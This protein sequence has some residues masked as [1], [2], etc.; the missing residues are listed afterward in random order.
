MIHSILSNDLVHALSWTLIHSLWQIIAIAFV[1]KVILKNIARSRANLRYYICFAALSV[2]SLTSL[3][4]FTSYYA[5]YQANKAERIYETVIT[6]N[7]VSVPASRPGSETFFS[8][9]ENYFPMLLQLWILGTLIFLIKI[10]LAYAYTKQLAANAQ[11]ES[12]FLTKT[13]KKLNKKFRIYRIINIKESSK[14]QTPMVLG[15]VKPLILFPVGLIN[16]LSTAEAEAIIAHE[17]AHIKRHDFIFN[18]LQMFVEAIFYFHPAIWHISAQINQERENCCDDM[19]IEYTGNKVSY[20]KTLIKLQ[21]LKSSNNLLAPALAM[22]GNKSSFSKRI[23]RLL[24]EKTPS[25]NHRDKIIVLLLVFISMFLGAKNMITDEKT[26][27]EFQL[28]DIYFI[29]DCPQSESELK[30]YLDTIPGRNSFH[31]KKMTDEKTVELEMQ[32]GE[33]KKLKI[34]G[35][36]IDKADYGKH[37]RIIQELKPDKKNSLITILPNCDDEMSE[38]YWIESKDGRA[39]KLDSIIDSE[40]KESFEKLRKY[41]IESDTEIEI[42]EIHDLLSDTL[43]PGKNAI[44]LKEERLKK[45]HLKLDSIWDLFPE[46][47][48]NIMLF[49][50][51]ENEEKQIIIELKEEL[52]N[53]EE[54]QERIIIEL[55]KEMGLTK[56][57]DERREEIIFE[58]EKEFTEGIDRDEEI[59]IVVEGFP[60]REGQAFFFSK[61]DSSNKVSDHISNNLLRDG[62]ISPEEVNTIELTGKFMKINGDK[63][64]KNIWKKYKKIYEKHT[65]IEM[66]KKSKLRF[67]LTPPEEKEIRLRRRMGLG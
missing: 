59:E 2:I 56:D 17:L 51:D 67:E 37:E 18:I 35:E 53:L 21:E 49:E 13:V 63:Q 32:N 20:A 8:G 54:E 5:G 34:D 36:E 25:S 61:D 39:V 45:K 24:N 40:K 12:T 62:L 26:A 28:P 60:K 46:K 33:I 52:G 58:I 22:S 66:H 15:Y 38:I 4:T 65:G 11:I 27:A 1:L 48:P 6:S 16:N 29:D 9:I 55:K 44:I 43:L 50:N 14:V 30:Y 42:E 64:P 57:E 41:W 10:I 23:L 7:N 47:M 19:A 3:I 31:V